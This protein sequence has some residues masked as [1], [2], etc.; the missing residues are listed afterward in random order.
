MNEASLYR[1]T[2]KSLPIIP[3][4]TI[5]DILFSC[6]KWHRKRIGGTWCLVRPV[7]FPEISVWTKNPQEKFERIEKIEYYL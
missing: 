1:K 6:Y 5:F 2:P 7:S 4:P 3:K